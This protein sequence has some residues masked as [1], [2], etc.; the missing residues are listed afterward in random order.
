MSRSASGDQKIHAI[1]ADPVPCDLDTVIAA[2]VR[3]ADS[4]IHCAAF[5][6]Q[7]GFPDAW[8]R[9]KQEEL[10]AKVA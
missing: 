8:D 5:V 1:G 4:V 10:N 2:D 3:G 9:I 7:W 6:E